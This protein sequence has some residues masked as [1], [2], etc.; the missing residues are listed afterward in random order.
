[1]AQ[2]VDY[3]VTDESPEC[4]IG[5]PIYRISDGEATVVAQGGLLQKPRG[6]VFDAAGQFIVADGFVGLLKVDPGTGAVTLIAAGPPY[7]P[8]DVKI[9]AQ[10]NYIVVDW[11]SGQN[12][13][14]GPPA[15]YRITPEGDVSIIA[16]GSPLLGPHGLAIDGGGNYIIGDPQAGVIRITPAGQ[17]TMV[18]P[19][20]PNGEL[21]KSADVAVDALG[22]YIVV[23]KS[24]GKLLRVSPEGIVTIIHG[25]PPFTNAD[26]GT[27]NG[28]RGV[29]VDDAGNYILVDEGARA[30]F[31][32]TPE[33]QASTIFQGDP[34]CGPADL[35]IVPAGN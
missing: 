7:N 8:R 22:N 27:A 33:G 24:K 34:L 2:L 23:D 17:M 18:V 25:G 31:Q 3:F 19:S 29:L 35:N 5:G 28:P 13:R 15:V 4:P 21:N 11:P 12:A 1:V 16:Q 14:L 10:G 9:D 26:S 30:I 32:V 20:S 6:G